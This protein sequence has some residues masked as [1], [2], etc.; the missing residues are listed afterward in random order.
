MKRSEKIALGVV[1][2]GIVGVVAFFVAASIAAHRHATALA[3]FPI[4]E[5][6]KAYRGNNTQ[7]VAATS[8]TERPSGVQ[9]SVDSF[10]KVANRAFAHQGE[11]WRALRREWEHSEERGADYWER[12]E[13]QIEKAQ[14]ALEALRA[15]AAQGGPLG[16]INLDEAPNLDLSHVWFL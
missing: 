1:V 16:T 2:L 12:W 10:Q 7:E 8:T 11:E 6:L 14:P 4:P 13:R 9:P 5:R 3:A 15:R